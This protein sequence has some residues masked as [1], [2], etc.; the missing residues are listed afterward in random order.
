MFNQNRPALGW[1][2]LPSVVLSH[3][4]NFKFGYSE[5]LTSTGFVAV[6]K[7]KDDWSPPFFPAPFKAVSPDLQQVISKS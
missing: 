3:R 7:G 6:A 4:P 1:L 5:L 2:Y